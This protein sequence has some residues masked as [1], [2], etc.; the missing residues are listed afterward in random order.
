METLAVVYLNEH[1]AKAKTDVSDL[2][3]CGEVFRSTTGI[4]SLWCSN[5][6]QSFVCL[7]EFT[8]HIEE[9]FQ[10]IRIATLNEQNVKIEADIFTPDS[11]TTEDT[12]ETVQFAADDIKIEMNENDSVK[13]KARRKVKDRGS[14]NETVTKSTKAKADKTSKIFKDPTNL[15]I[16]DICG[17]IFSTKNH[18]YQHMKLH[19]KAPKEHKCYM[20]GWEFYEKG[21]LTRHLRTHNKD[22]KAF[23]CELCNKGTR[24]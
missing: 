3:K 21:N 1:E 2:A 10:L 18:I 19:R 20:C 7:A 12:K 11:Q 6:N 13:R 9:H 14:G 22:S 24:I 4:Y 5:C 15:W 17:K 8:Q 23:K 16:C